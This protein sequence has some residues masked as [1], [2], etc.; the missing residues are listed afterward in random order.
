MTNNIDR[1]NALLFMSIQN[2]S[3]VGRWYGLIPGIHHPD[4]KCVDKLFSHRIEYSN[5]SKHG[6]PDGVVDRSH[7]D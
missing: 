6:K 4:Y 7:D 3:K 1:K 5:N 2:L